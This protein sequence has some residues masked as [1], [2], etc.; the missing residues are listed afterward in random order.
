MR[1]HFFKSLFLFVAIILFSAAAPTKVNPVEQH[2]LIAMRMIGHQ[3]LLVSCDSSSRV[4]PVENQDGKYKIQFESNFQFNPDDLVLVIDSILSISHVACH[5]IVEVV[6]CDNDKVVYG[7]EKNCVEEDDLIPCRSRELHHGCFQ[8]FISILERGEFMASASG[9]SNKLS[10]LIP[11]K[12]LLWGQFIPVLL[13]IVMLFLMLRKK[14]KTIARPE[15]ISIGRYKL[16]K[17]NMNLI[18]ENSRIELTSTE[19]DLLALLHESANDTLDRDVILNKVWGDNG[20]YVGRTLDVFIS[21]LRAKLGSD[22]SVRI[23]NIRG[24]GY[25]LVLND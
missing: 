12:L 4:L 17:K 22:D 21:K 2:T 10:T 25:K 24:K 8:I 16:D 3:I 18:F 19:S 14:S 7:Y 1:P 20:D 5:Y 6:D 9:N 11:D 15:L 13:L 23:V